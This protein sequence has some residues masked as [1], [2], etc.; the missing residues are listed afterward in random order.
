MLDFY[1]QLWR[2]FRL[3]D[4]NNPES[5]WNY[6]LTMGCTEGN[7]YGLWNARDHLAGRILVE[8]SETMHEPS[9]TVRGTKQSACKMQR[10]QLFRATTS[11]NHP[12]AYTSAAFCSEDTH[13]SV[14]KIMRILGIQTFSEV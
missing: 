9:A 7:L 3:Y 11:A 4:A 12:H 14:I 10:L 1:A 8:G 13:Y 2:A 5:Y 6:V